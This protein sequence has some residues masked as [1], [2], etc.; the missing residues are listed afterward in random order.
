MRGN[1]PLKQIQTTSLCNNS[2]VRWTMRQK[3]AK[4]QNKGKK[5]VTLLA[6]IR[7]QQQSRMINNKHTGPRRDLIIL[8]RA[9]KL[10]HLYSISMQ[11]V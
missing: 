7:K 10:L 5:K 11:T 8:S 1:S 9:S 6:V 4:S 2:T 3:E